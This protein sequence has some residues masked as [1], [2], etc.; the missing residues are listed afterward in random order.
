MEIKWN[1]LIANIAVWTVAEIT[2]NAIGLDTI[3]DYS[4]FLTSKH[5]TIVIEQ[6]IAHQ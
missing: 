3:A 4:E 2:L 5:Q 1:K 6:A